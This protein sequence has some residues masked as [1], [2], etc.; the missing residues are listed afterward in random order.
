MKDFQ[1]SLN[2]VFTNAG[3]AFTLIFPL[4]DLFAVLVSVVI[5][6]YISID[7]KAN[8]FLGCALVIC[9]SLIS[10]AFYYVS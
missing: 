6:N 4:L 3:A 7:G 1:F 2:F 8:Y 9:Y 5:V 10:A